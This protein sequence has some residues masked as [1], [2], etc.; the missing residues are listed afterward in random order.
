MIETRNF[1]D[2]GSYGPDGSARVNVERLTRISNNELQY[3]IT[4]NDPGSFAAPYTRQIVF[5]HS[6]DPIFEYAC[7]EG[8]Y[9]MGYILLGHRADERFAREASAANTQD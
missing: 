6:L 7:H 9:G 3:E 1:S 5:D 8:N 2:K 4:S